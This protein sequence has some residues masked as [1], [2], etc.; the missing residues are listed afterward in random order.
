MHEGGIEVQVLDDGAL[1]FVKPD[2]VSI[3]SVLPG[4]T[5]PFS[6]WTDVT[7]ANERLGIRIYHR[8]AATRWDG[9]TMNYGLGVEVLL[10]RARKAKRVAAERQHY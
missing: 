1:R 8:T 9:T 5:Q 3:D 4:Y 2:G 7:K 6:V 10:Q